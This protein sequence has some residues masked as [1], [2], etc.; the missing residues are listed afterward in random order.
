[1][2]FFNH[3]IPD[4]DSNNSK[5]ADQNRV[6]N[7]YRRH[8]ITSFKSLASD[9]CGIIFIHISTQQQPT[10]TVAGFRILTAHYFDLIY[11]NIHPCRCLLVCILPKLHHG[12]LE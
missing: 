10:K 3:P 9:I 4:I 11:G 2:L 12:R 6:P 1:M 5:V 8:R 7:G